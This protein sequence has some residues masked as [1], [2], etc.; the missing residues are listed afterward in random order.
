[1]TDTRYVCG[2]CQTRT[3]VKQVQ[4][5]LNVVEDED[6]DYMWVDVDEQHF[7]LL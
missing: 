6:A 5:N 1:M 3:S 2:M 4:A 7:Y